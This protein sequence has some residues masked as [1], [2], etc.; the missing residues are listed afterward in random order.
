MR[1]TLPIVLKA[2]I[3][4]G[5]SVAASI[6]PLCADE[7]VDGP[8]LMQR[9]R[10]D[11]AW[12]G[13]L[14][15]FQLAARVEERQTPEGLEQALKKIKEQNPGLEQPDPLKF[16][17]LQS[18]WN[19]RTELAFDARRLRLMTLWRDGTNRELDRRVQMW[20]ARRSTDH[21]QNFRSGEDRIHF[22]S[23]ISSVAGDFGI[24]F[25][26]LR[27]Q[28]LDCWW[29]N[30]GKQRQELREFYGIPSDFVLVG[31]E[32]YHGVDCHVVLD[33]RAHYSD[34]YYIGVK[35]GRRYG[36][37]TGVI[38]VANRPEYVET[39]RRLFQEFLGKSLGDGSD[40]EYW[41]AVYQQLPA[42]S[43]ARRAAWGKRSYSEIGKRFTPVWEYWYSDFRD[44]GEG[45]FLPFRETHLFYSHDDGDKKSFVRSQR[46]TFVRKLTLVQTLDDSL[47]DEPI[48]AGATVVDD[49]PK[50]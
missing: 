25:G 9:V 16:T 39:H 15:S 21:F 18:E 48:A 32:S 33:A 12:V 34:R 4:V 29:N 43:A 24:W 40:A 7:A 20:D 42:L 28:P 38:S 47:F 35:N 8:A 45:R 31:R 49:V 26:Y 37:Q 10:D 2:V 46:T 41:A 19:V 13:K 17:E 36:A 50:P 22:G 44:L 30:D 23:K 27:S 6:W 3:V 14:E 1:M 5:I 11:I